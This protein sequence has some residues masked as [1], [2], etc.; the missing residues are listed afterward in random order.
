[1]LQEMKV[2]YDKIKSSELMQGMTLIGTHRDD[3]SILNGEDYCTL[4]S[5]TV[6]GDGSVSSIANVIPAELVKIWESHQ[7]R[8]YEEALK[9]QAY[10]MDMCTYLEM[11]ET[12]AYQSACKTALREMGYYSTNYVSSPFQEILATEEKH[13]VEL[14]RKRMMQTL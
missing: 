8:K 14:T 3:F 9:Q 2:K 12:G 5:Y 10:I 1:M 6:G 7:N 13:I 11:V 4:P